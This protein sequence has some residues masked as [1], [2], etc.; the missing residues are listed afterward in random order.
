MDDRDLAEQFETHRSHLRA[1][2]YRMLGSAGEADD[3][4]QDAWL[5]LARSDVSEVQSLRGWLTT[6]V[7][8]LCLDMLRSRGSRREDPFDPQTSG[9]ATP[10][11]RRIGDPEEETLMIDSV[12]RALL[13]VLDRLG[14]AERIAF[15]LHDMFAV[16]FDE[17]API[18]D[19]STDATKKLASRARQRVQG[20]PTISADDLKRHRRVVDAFLDATRRGDVDAVLAVLAPDVV[21]RADRVVLPAGAEAVLRGA[22]D[23]AQETRTNAGRARSADLALVG[24]TVGLVVAPHGRLYVAIRLAIVDDRITDIDVVGDPDRLR[25]LDLAVL[26]V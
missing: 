6:V 13:V 14:A 12:G 11:G 19:R 5:R 17:I 25:N 21:R 18:V 23:V 10:A 22:D 8:R 7:S 2:A 16:P 3:A 9:A 15:V 24:G 4:V 1:V 20:T 26:A